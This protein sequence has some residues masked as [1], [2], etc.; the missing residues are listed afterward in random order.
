MGAQP[1][2]HR[3]QHDRRVVLV[4]GGLDPDRLPRNQREPVAPGRRQF[5]QQ[6]RRKPFDRIR[7]RTVIQRR[8]P[9]RAGRSQA[10]LEV[11]LRQ[12]VGVAF[13]PQPAPGIAPF[14]GPAMPL[15]ERHD[16]VCVGRHAHSPSRD[17]RRPVRS[18][19]PSSPASPVTI[20]PRRP[21][22]TRLIRLRRCARSP[23]PVIDRFGG[24][25]RRWRC[26]CRENSSHRRLLP[27]SGP[28]PGNKKPASG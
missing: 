4:I 11:A 19:S 26:G 1:L 21:R 23:L 28:A 22:R 25:G 15:G 20:V 9:D 18:R 2:G 3:L 16:G 24:N 13:A 27:F 17:R 5:S 10:N 6:A 12:G 14:D 8:R 7:C